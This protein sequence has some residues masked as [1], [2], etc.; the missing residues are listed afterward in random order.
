MLLG[1][2]CLECDCEWEYFSGEEY[3]IMCPY[4]ESEEFEEYHEMHCEDCGFEF[5]GAEGDC[6]PE[7]GGGETK[8]IK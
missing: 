6:C 4:C 8:I 2:H 3:P 5:V 7:C 1:F